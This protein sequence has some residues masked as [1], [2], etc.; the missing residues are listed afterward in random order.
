MLKRLG[1][2]QLGTL[3]QPR[4][5]AAA[6]SSSSDGGG[7]SSSSSSSGGGGSRGRSQESSG[8]GSGSSSRCAPCWRGPRTAGGR[9]SPCGQVGGQQRVGAGRWCWAHRHA[10]TLGT[11]S[12]ASMQ[13][14]PTATGRSTRGPG[15]RWHHSVPM[16]PC[17]TTQKPPPEDRLHDL[18]LALAHDIHRLRMVHIAEVCSGATGDV[19]GGGPGAVAEPAS[20]SARRAGLE[21]APHTQQ[22]TCGFDH[23]A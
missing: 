10:S 12:H 14:C 17:M 16:S 22:G 15:W 3:R 9:Q 13:L 1:C 11:L 20:G 6:S 7:G 23:H 19:G 18:D 2:L 5:V 21:G 8:N 4:G